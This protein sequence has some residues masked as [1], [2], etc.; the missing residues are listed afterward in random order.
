[1][2]RDIL[3]LAK[4]EGRLIPLSVRFDPAELVAELQDVWS[5]RTHSRDLR[6]FVLADPVRPL[7]CRGCPHR[8]VSMA[9]LLNAVKFTQP[10]ASR[11]GRRRG[12][13]GSCSPS[14]TP[15]QA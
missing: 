14:G 13:T 10:A 7:L 9:L 4:L 2:R 15:V 8:R 11:S 3:D 6:F 1:M 12:A 5:A